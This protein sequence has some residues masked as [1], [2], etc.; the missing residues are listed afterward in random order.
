MESTQTYVIALPT[1]AQGLLADNGID[2]VAALREEGLNVN[3]AALPANA[4]APDGGKEV[5]LTLLAVG[6]TVSMVASGIAKILDALGRNRKFLVTEHTLEPIFDATG[7][8]LKNAAG[9]PCFQWSDKK[10]LIEATQTTQDKGSITAEAGPSLLRF[11]ITS[12]K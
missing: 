1:E 12:G 2:L 5:V 3:R 8:P 7:A 11:S 9:Q 10:R 6:L 4:P